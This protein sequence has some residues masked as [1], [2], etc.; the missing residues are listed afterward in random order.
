MVSSF[1]SQAGA[2]LQTTSGH[3]TQVLRVLT[4]AADDRCLGHQCQDHQA[5]LQNGPCLVMMDI[6]SDWHNS[7]APP[8][9]GMAI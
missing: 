7:V 6:Q 5:L 2:N 4:A 1:A 9:K 3:T 8:Y